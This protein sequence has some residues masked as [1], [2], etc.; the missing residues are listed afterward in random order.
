MTIL[1]GLIN[2]LI[3]H[4]VPE[5][6]MKGVIGACKGFFDL[7]EE[8]KRQFD[9]KDVMDP[10]K[11]GTSVNSSIENVLFWRDYLKTHVHPEF[12]FPNKPP[13]FRYNG[14][15]YSFITPDIRNQYKLLNMFLANIYI[16]FFPLST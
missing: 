8:E 11:C 3:N 14:Y 2:Q 15:I 16:F 13:G 5:K 10:I 1:T 6:L 12:H 4:G 7:S 9:G